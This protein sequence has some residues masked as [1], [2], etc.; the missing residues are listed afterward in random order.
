MTEL[1]L[2]CVACGFQSNDAFEF[3]GHCRGHEAEEFYWH[4][5]DIWSE[6]AA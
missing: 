3:V 4:A 6:T 1:D 5:A 2:N